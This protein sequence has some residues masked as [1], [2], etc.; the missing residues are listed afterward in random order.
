[1]APIGSVPLIPRLDWLS[2]CIGISTPTG[3]NREIGHVPRNYE[4][5]VQNI[6]DTALQ[7]ISAFRTAK[8]PIAQTETRI[9]TGTPTKRS[10]QATGPR[11]IVVDWFSAAV[12]W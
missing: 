2:R 7:F 5:Y 10:T 3:G 11:W 8:Y 12:L 1:M 4:H 6:G 9:Q